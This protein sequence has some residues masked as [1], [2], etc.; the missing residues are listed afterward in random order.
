MFGLVGAVV[1]H[2]KYRIGN[3]RTKNLI[4]PFVYMLAAQKL[5][6]CYVIAIHKPIPKLDA[7]N[8]WK[9]MHATVK[10]ALLQTPV[11]NLQTTFETKVLLK[12]YQW[13]ALTQMIWNINTINVVSFFELQIMCFLRKIKSLIFSKF[14]RIFF[15]CILLYKKFKQKENNHKKYKAFHALNQFIGAILYAVLRL[16]KLF[17]L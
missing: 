6:L 16:I 9:Q 10:C 7:T 14:W 15:R 1:T 11:V 13:L 8:I 4:I 5:W 3:F 17:L 12:Y 2:V